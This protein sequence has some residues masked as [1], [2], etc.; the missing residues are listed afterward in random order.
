M[1]S[2]KIDKRRRKTS[3]NEKIVTKDNK[4]PAKRKTPVKRKVIKNAA[5][6]KAE[7]SLDIDSSEASIDME[8]D[9]HAKV[10]SLDE[11]SI[12]TDDENSDFIHL[13]IDQNDTLLKTSLSITMSEEHET[14]DIVYKNTIKRNKNLWSESEVKFL[15][16]G[17]E[18]Y[19]NEVNKWAKI[20]KDYDFNGR[21]AVDLKD[22][23]RIMIK[24]TSYHVNTKKQYVLVDE[25]RNVL[26]DEM[27]GKKTYYEKFPYEAATR[28]AKDL[29]FPNEK[30]FVI[31][32]MPT[33]NSFYKYI[34]KKTKNGLVKVAPVSVKYV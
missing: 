21:K 24:K 23:H 29:C 17:Y 33:L 20:L 19:K 28:I 8:E 31:S 13:Y 3:L 25:N 16:E 1:K 4:S 14:P 6:K 9:H 27:G 34:V 15:M 10:V 32:Y 5:R 30:D 12:I 7:P 18:K 2:P 22:K 11:K 26:Y